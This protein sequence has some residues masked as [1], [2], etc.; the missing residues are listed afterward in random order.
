MSSL[1]PPTDHLIQVIISLPVR[2]VV[3]GGRIP[4]LKA[5]SAEKINIWVATWEVMSSGRL[6]SA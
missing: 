1:S 4:A 2:E 6:K 5:D 3:V